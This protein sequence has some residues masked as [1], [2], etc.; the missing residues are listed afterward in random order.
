MARRSTREGS[1]LAG[2]GQRID[3]TTREVVASI[4]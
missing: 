3:A 4:S 1:L 2:E